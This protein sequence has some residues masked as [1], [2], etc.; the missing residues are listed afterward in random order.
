MPAL[1]REHGIDRFTGFPYS[2]FT[3]RV[4]G[5]Y[6]AEQSL[7]ACRERYEAV[8]EATMQEAERHQVSIELPL[9]ASQKQVSFGLERRGFL[10]FARVEANDWPLLGFV[11]R[12]PLARPARPACGF[13]WRQASAVS[14]RRFNVPGETHYLNPC[15]GPLSAVDL[16]RPTAFRFPALA[17]F[18]ALWRNPVFSLLR[19]G[20]RQEGLSPVCD[21]CRATDT[22]DPR[23]FARLNQLVTD[24]AVAHSGRVA[25]TQEVGSSSS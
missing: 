2:S 16:S 8:Y 21:A 12:I 18:G 10:D 17:D 15:L 19:A 20:Q 4:G 9:P 1:C 6:G 11:N 14:T 5:K 3:I 25:P 22:R 23:H 24:F 13:L 7:E